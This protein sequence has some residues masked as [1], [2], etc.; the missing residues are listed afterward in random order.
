MGSHL[1]PSFQEKLP[2]G[3][4][5][6]FWGSTFCSLE[7]I[8][9]ARAPSDLRSC[10]NW[11][12]PR[13]GRGSTAGSS[14]YE[15][16]CATWSLW[17]SRWNNIWGLSGTKGCCLELLAGHHRWV[18]E[19][20]L[21]SLDQGKL[22]S[23]NYFPLERELV[24]SFWASMQCELLTTSQR[25]TNWH[26]LPIMSGALLNPPDHEVGCAQPSRNP[27][28]NGSGIHMVMSEK[29]LKAQLSYV[30]KLLKCVCVCVFSCL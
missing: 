15:G 30:K 1:F 17:S 9:L 26:E 21:G 28:S 8:F 10:W 13:I 27:P 5:L 16:C 19:D 23:D 11:V 24:A 22:S 25:V 12:G 7:C 18:M 3:A 20:A 4:S 2:N 14:C 29:I 6:D